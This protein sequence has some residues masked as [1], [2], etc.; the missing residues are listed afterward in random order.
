MFNQLLSSRLIQAGFAF[1]VIVVGGLLYSWHAQRMTEKEM[2]ALT[3]ELNAK[4][5]DIVELGSLP[6]EEWLSRYPTE[7]AF[8]ALG[9]RIDAM[10]SEFG[11]RIDALVAEMPL[12]HQ[13][14]FITLLGDVAAQN[15]GDEV[16]NQMVGRLIVNLE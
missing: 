11:E 15:W 14:E 12:D 7:A 4:Y 9:E 1:C 10:Q 2:A 5:P 16:A 3:A 6:L 13:I 8:E